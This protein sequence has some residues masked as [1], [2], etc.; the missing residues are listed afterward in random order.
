MS[1]A[2]RL[3]LHTDLAACLT[4]RTDMEQACSRRQVSVNR[5]A[6]CWMHDLHLKAAPCKSC[7]TTRN[8]SCHAAGTPA[9]CSPAWQRREWRWSNPARL[10]PRSPSLPA[11]AQHLRTCCSCQH[12]KRKNAETARGAT[13]TVRYC[14][15]CCLL[16][17]RLAADALHTATVVGFFVSEHGQ[18]T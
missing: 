11:Q 18:C 2:A 15:P 8:P 17:A 7:Y 1:A 3:Q 14:M 12:D 9:G 6:P 13:H 16:C 4:R 5:E 10:P